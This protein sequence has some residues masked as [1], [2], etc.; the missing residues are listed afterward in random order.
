MARFVDGANRIN[1]CNT[2]C[3]SNLKLSATRVYV[4]AIGFVLQQAVDNAMPTRQASCC[5]S[6][7]QKHATWQPLVLLRCI[8]ALP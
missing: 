2:T 8:L 4:S 6:A 3:G 1:Q 7:Q 5:H